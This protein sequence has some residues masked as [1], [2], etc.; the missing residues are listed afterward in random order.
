MNFILIGVVVSFVLTGVT[1]LASQ[2]LVSTLLVFLLTNA[3]FVLLVKRWMDKNQLKIH[4]YHQCFQFI[5]SF[6][7]SLNV[8][9]SLSAAFQSSYETTD[10]ETKEI[11]DSIKE[12]N[13]EEKLTYLCKHFKFDLYRLFV[14]V[15][16]LWNEEGGDILKMSQYLINQARLKEQY[17][18]TCET[19]HRQ[20]TIEFIVLWAISLAI[21]GMLRF[22][23]SQFFYRISQTLFYQVAVVSIILFALFSIY[24]LIMRINKIELEGWSNEN[25]QD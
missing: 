20:K 18:L 10:Q 8:K 22:A 21:L 19:I 12:L 1:F 25:K 17:L 7:I 23:L 13:E 5:N 11:V 24:I 16:M 14:D 3:F 4:R 2:N 15:V 6:I 9:G